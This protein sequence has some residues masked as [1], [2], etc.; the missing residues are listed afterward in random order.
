[1]PGWQVP[2]EVST[3]Q[4]PPAQLKLHSQAPSSLQ[5]PWP[6]QSFRQ[7]A[8]LLIVRLYPTL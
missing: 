5:V 1:M 8:C 2:T 3:E 7:D 6:E 4:S